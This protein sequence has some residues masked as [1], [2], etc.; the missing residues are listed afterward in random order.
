MLSDIISRLLSFMTSTY[1]STPSNFCR[2]LF[3]WPRLWEHNA[4]KCV[5]YGIHRSRFKEKFSRIQNVVWYVICSKNICIDMNVGK[6]RT[7]SVYTF[8]NNY[9]IIKVLQSAK[10][11]SN[12][13]ACNHFIRWEFTV[14]NLIWL[15][16]SYV[17]FI[18]YLAQ[19]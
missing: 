4:Q 1:R 13:H 18:H 3:S 5:W 19:F 15:S 9:M 10:I 12:F 2:V 17:T 6:I 7:L 14:N 8:N 11:E 16:C